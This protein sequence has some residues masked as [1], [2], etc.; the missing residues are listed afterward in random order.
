MRLL[1]NIGNRYTAPICGRFSFSDFSL[2]NNI[3][4]IIISFGGTFKKIG[5]SFKK[6]GGTFQKIGGT[7]PLNSTL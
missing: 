4:I 6:S 5:G 7:T 3:I 1:R 2:H